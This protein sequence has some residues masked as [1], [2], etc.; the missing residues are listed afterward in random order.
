M[1]PKEIKVLHDR[2]RKDLGDLT[3]LT[4][5]IKKYGLFHPI[6]IDGNNVLISGERRLRAC[7]LNGMDNIPTSLYSGL[8]TMEKKEIEL[9]ENIRR[10]ALEW[11][12][13]VEAKAALHALKQRI[14]GIAFP[15]QSTG[16]RLQ[17][18]ADQL[19]E[20]LGRISEDILLANAIQLFPQ[21]KDEPTKSQ[22]LNKY[23]R[24]AEQGI[25]AIMAE[26]KEQDT[27]SGFKKGDCQEL[28]KQLKDKSVDLINTDPPFG[29]NL[30]TAFDFKKTYD[31][32]YSFEDSFSNWSSLMRN[33]LKELFRVLKDDGHMYIF[34]ASKH[35][36]DMISLVSKS[37]FNYD[38]I[39]C[40]WWKG[41]S[42]GTTYQPFQR[43]RPN[44]EPFLFC[45]KGSPRFL[46]SHRGAVFHYQGLAGQVKRHPAEKPCELGA[47][48]TMLS[49]VEG[50][51]VLDPFAGVGS[52][53][54][55]ALKLKRKVIA[56]EMDEQYFN[57]L[58]GG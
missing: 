34:F 49:S 33:V 10:K 53:I 37:G 17:D 38:P 28:L 47:E 14:E 4:E 42:G 24:L 43:F 44:Y 2:Q 13:E 45:W 26:G 57:I 58:V 22:A 11:Q 18:T 39:P 9:E 40:I 12:E 54:L 3:G 8:S 25:R 55:P 51:V 29:V 23:K 19:S 41:E 50:E 56:M 36:P 35:Y 15:G 27:P 46:N 16:W 5:S 52:L 1:N 32:P 31:K 20:S 48:L 21:L 30:D 7:I 6:I